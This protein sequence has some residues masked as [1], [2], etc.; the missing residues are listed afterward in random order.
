MND[1][2]RYMIVDK[3]TGEVVG[4][5]YTKKEHPQTF[6][7]I[8]AFIVL[9]LLS[10]ATR[11]VTYQYIRLVSWLLDKIYDLSKLVYYVILFFG[12]ASAFGLLIWG[13][14]LG[15]N[16][17]FSLSEKVIPSRKGSRYM[18]LGIVVA[19]FY[20]LS[21]IAMIAGISSDTSAQQYVWHIIIIIFFVVFA[22]YGKAQ[23]SDEKD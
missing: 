6:K 22:F 1:E 14:V 11:F 5:S 19:A 9:Y 20:L 7:R 23:K 13:F 2:K 17:M 21:L 10:L 18:V 8:L 12:G 15:A 16:G 4:E 3:E